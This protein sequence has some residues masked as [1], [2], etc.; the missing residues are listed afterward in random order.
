MRDHNIDD[1]DFD[2]GAML[3]LSMSSPAKSKMTNNS[4]IRKRKSAFPV[5][6]APQDLPTKPKKSFF[7][8]TIGSVQEREAKK[9][10]LSSSS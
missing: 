2:S 3:L 4:P 8:S 6:E 10:R 9:K 7:A 1:N 5:H